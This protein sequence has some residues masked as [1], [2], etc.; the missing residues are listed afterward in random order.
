LEL[1]IVFAGTEVLMST[2][3]LWARRLN[4]WLLWFCRHWG[5]SLGL[6]LLLLVGLP[7]LA[8][9]FMKLGWENAGKAIYLLYTPLCHQM[10]QR[11]YF[12]FGT[13]ASYNLPAIQ[14]AW[15]LTD[16]PL[17]LRQFLGNGTM[18]WKVAW[19]DRMV[20]MYSS[21]LLWGG[22]LWPW[23]HRLKRLPWWGLILFILPIFLDGSS[24]LV[25]DI[26]GGVGGGFRY[27]NGWLAQLT[28]N[29]MPA[30]FYIGDALGSFNS[31]M[32]LL[33]G[34]LFGLGAVWFVLP[35]LDEGFAITARQIEAKLERAGL[36]F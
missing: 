5:L 1:D 4:R 32:R 14:S 17:I 12:L 26:L 3:R 9:L 22:L 7:W 21:P 2:N 33:T 16:N 31:W 34:L 24:H 13:Q 20:S 30:S 18:G 36:T 10:P 35:L 19:S 28:G 6:P 15:R 25:S 23:R 27:D 29:Q 11:S 8:P